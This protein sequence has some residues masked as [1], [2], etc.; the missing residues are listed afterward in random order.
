MIHL[1]K[2][3]REGP[4]P[5]F[6]ALQP[7]LFLMVAGVSVAVEEGSTVVA[8][9]EGAVVAMVVVGGPAMSEVSS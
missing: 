9:A 4:A 6:L 3:Q 5:H 7:R 2:H 8:G 1:L